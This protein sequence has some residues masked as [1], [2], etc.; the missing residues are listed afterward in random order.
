MTALETAL[1]GLS[2]GTPVTHA[3]LTL[4]PLLGGDAGEPAYLTLGEALAAGQ[5][6]ITEVSEQGSVPEL[7]FVNE[8]ARPVLLLDGEELVGAKQ[9]R[10][11]N[12][13]ILVPANSELVIPVSCVEAGRWRH[14]SESFMA[15]ERAH[16]ARGRAQK[17]AD[18]SHSLASRGERRSDQGAVWE[19]IRM[20]AGRMQAES[21]TAAAAAM[22]EANAHKLDDFVQAM[23]PAPGQC[24]AAF[25]VNGALLGV[26]LFDASATYAKQAKKLLTS[27]ALDAIDESR[28]EAPSAKPEDCRALLADVLRA[29][30]RAFKAVGLGEDLRLCG[31][32]VK[33]AA[34]ELDGRVVHLCAFREQSGQA[35]RGEGAAG[36]MVRASRRRNLH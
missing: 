26:D 20:K 28:H 12:L 7:R 4:F 32:G 15:A 3:N 9:N 31:A 14:E 10:I 30:C 11:V 8:A 23:P 24:G 34:L 27:Y 19:E 22:Y 13:S 29:D 16:F 25:A 36:R 6:R 33:G 35:Q 18:V 2:L 5:A 17:M 21:S 1:T